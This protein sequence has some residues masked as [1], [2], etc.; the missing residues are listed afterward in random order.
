MLNMSESGLKIDTSKKLPQFDLPVDFIVY[1][2]I[3]A[4][5][6]NFYGNFPCKI[7]AFILAFCSKGSVKATINLWDY[8]IKQN[9]FI[10]LTPGS[11]IQIKE[12]SDDIQMGF[13]G[14]SSKFLNSMNFWKSMSTL[15]MPIFKNPIL[16]LQPDLASIYGDSLSLLT[17]ASELSDTIISQNIIKHILTLFIDSITEAINKNLVIQSNMPSSREQDVV[18]EF[19]QLAFENY[20]DEHKITFYAHEIN[21]TLSHFCSVISKT[22]GM[23]PQEIIMHLIIMDAKAQLKGTDATVTKI[24]SILGFAT[25]TTFNRYF[26]TYTGMTP[27]EYRFS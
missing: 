10:I 20:R 24:A 15:L 4:S 5:L 19:L 17:R 14:F 21:L 2:K 25:P 23:T 22:T 18:A 27:Q 8:D 3:Y 9:D 1:D 13:A 6:L 16:T 7:D 12:V 11:F 26:K